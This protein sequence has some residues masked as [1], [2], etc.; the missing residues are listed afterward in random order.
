[1]INNN[2]RK[3]GLHDILVWVLT[4]ILWDKDICAN[5]SLAGEKTLRGVGK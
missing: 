2:N 3:I 5:I 1:M 4:N